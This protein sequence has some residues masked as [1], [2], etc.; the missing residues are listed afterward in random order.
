MKRNTTPTS[1]GKHDGPEGRTGPAEGRKARAISHRA[2]DVSE[3]IF[4]KIQQT[5]NGIVLS[6]TRQVVASE[7]LT[8][9]T[10]A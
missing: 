6:R 2:L 3:A 4:Q 8:P 5:A 1:N 9:P 7:G 10:R